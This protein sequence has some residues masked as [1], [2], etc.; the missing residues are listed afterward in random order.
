MSPGSFVAES[1]AFERVSYYFHALRYRAALFVAPLS[2]GVLGTAFRLAAGVAEL[3]DRP[4][5]LAC[6]YLVDLVDLTGS[7]PAIGSPSGQSACATSEYPRQA[8]APNALPKPRSFPKAPE[9]PRVP[10]FLV[11][12]WRQALLPHPS[13]AHP[14]SPR[15]IP[16][17]P[18]LD[19]RRPPHQA[20]GE[21]RGIP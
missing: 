16:A 9:N 3:T 19:Q 5:R 21:G 17:G 12:R 15:L 14:E 18:S 13:V 4:A 20:H 6:G 1:I 11:A 2:A 10:R 7:L 8:C